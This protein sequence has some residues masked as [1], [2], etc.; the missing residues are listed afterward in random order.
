MW[1]KPNFVVY[2]VLCVLHWFFIDRVKSYYTKMHKALCTEL[3]FSHWQNSQLFESSVCL[4]W[5][6]NT[7]LCWIFW[8]NRNDRRMSP[9]TFLLDKF[10]LRK[11]LSLVKIILH[12]TELKGHPLADIYFFL[13]FCKLSSG[14]AF[15]FFNFWVEY[16]WYPSVLILSFSLVVGWYV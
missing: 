10:N 15:E 6:Q 4:H 3:F 16:H 11:I 2:S 1:L 9:G 12:C 7:L 13:H 8:C 5:I 14:T